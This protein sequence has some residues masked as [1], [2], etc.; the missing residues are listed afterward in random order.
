MLTLRKKRNLIVASLVI[1]N[2]LIASSLTFASET[3][4]ILVNG[5]LIEPDVPAQIINGRTMAPIRF[6]SQALDANVDWDSNS[7]T[8]IIKDST[9]SGSND[10]SPQDDSIV[11]SE[12]ILKNIPVIT[13]GTV[14][15]KSFQDE[16]RIRVGVYQTKNG[17]MYGFIV[18][19]RS[20]YA[21][22]GHDIFN[23]AISV[24]A[25]STLFSLDDLTK[26]TVESE[27]EK[28]YLKVIVPD[29]KE[30]KGSVEAAVLIKS[31]VLGAVSIEN[32]YGDAYILVKR[33]IDN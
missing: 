11:A 31:F 4:K 30:G 27:V 17:V 19:G 20:H 16:N 8:V 24:L 3:I 14:I 26:D 33:I 7:K 2:L 32:S 18:T 22:E 23:A 5:T 9:Y 21:P 29:L 15:D 12:T 25:Q 13:D 10:P 1:I 28:G 6:V